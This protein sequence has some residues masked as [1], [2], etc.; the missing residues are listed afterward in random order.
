MRV[1]VQDRVLVE[2][3]IGGG[4]AKV[5][6]EVPELPEAARELHPH[7]VV[8]GVLPSDAVG[9]VE[10]ARQYEV[11]EGRGGAVAGVAVNEQ[12]AWQG[13]AHAEHQVAVK[14]D[15][16]C[17]RRSPRTSGTVTVP[18]VPGHPSNAMDATTIRPMA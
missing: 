18:G 17:A 16:A 10:R 9:V 7:A 6:G 11:G 2:Q 13:V 8:D 5:A 12:V 3:L 14:E 1:D 15:C 4:C